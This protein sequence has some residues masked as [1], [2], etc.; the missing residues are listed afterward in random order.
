LICVRLQVW[1]PFGKSHSLIIQNHSAEL[2]ELSAFVSFPFLF[3]MGSELPANLKAGESIEVPIKVGKLDSDSK[4]LRGH[5]TLFGAH[6]VL[7]STFSSSQSQC[8]SKN[9]VLFFRSD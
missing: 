6:P 7:Q 4:M 2:R 8:Q 3:E 1:I 5:L 9:D